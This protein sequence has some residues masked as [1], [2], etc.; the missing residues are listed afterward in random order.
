MSM[1]VILSTAFGRAID[2]Q[3]GN[4]GKLYEAAIDVFADFVPGESNQM[5]ATKFIELL[6]SEPTNA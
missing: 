2:V 3:G 6:T 1:E 4:G 5:N